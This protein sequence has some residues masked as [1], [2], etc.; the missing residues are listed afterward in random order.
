ME[1]CLQHFGGFMSISNIRPPSD[2]SKN[3]L[4]MGPNGT[5]EYD[6]TE[7]GEYYLALGHNSA[8]S[9]KFTAIF[10]EEFLA[11]GFLLERLGEVKAGGSLTPDFRLAKIAI[12]S[13]R[14]PS[15]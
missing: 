5:E 14:A 8:I 9:C 4:H 10:V 6:L 2:F 15:L 7:A 3:F 11:R 12:L 1:A 13:K